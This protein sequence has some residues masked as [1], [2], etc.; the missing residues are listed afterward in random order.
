MDR[1]KV[2]SDLAMYNK[3]I[4]LGLANRTARIMFAARVKADK[5]ITKKNVEYIKV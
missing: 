1:I 2:G 3:R 5:Y 4:T